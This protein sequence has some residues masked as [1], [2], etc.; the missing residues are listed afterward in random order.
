[1]A[2]EYFSQ[3]GLDEMGL[4]EKDREILSVL[5]TEENGGFISADTLAARVHLSAG[6]LTSEYEPYLLKI[7]YMGITSRGRYLSEEGR[8]YIENK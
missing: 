2:E 1:M 5:N 3:R 6:V 7:G 8:K 4:G